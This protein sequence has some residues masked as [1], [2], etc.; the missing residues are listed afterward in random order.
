MGCEKRLLANPDK[1][2]ANLEQPGPGKEVDPE[3]AQALAT[4]SPSDRALAEKQQTCPVADMTL[5][6][7]GT[8]IKV[9]VKGTPVFIC[10]EGCREELL[11]N[12][13]TYLAK[14][15][16]GPSS[17]APQVPVPEMDLPQSSIPEVP[18]M[19]FSIPEVP[20][21]PSVDEGVQ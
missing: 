17:S 21:M 19:E 11:E 6:S 1:Y 9:D 15:A 13:A 2:L 8:P 18:D 20:E 16:T 14:L 3:I 12:S 5:G 10:C 4:L 7:M